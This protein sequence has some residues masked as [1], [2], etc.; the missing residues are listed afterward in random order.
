MNNK[1]GNSPDSTNFIL[2]QRHGLEYLTA[3]KILAGSRANLFKMDHQRPLA[4]LLGHSLELTF[5]GLLSIATMSAGEPIPFTHDLDKLAS[6]SNIQSTLALTND[7]LSALVV[8]N[9][10]FA[11]PYIARYPKL[12]LQL[13]P[14]PEAFSI[15]LNL[16][17]R[18]SKVLD[19]LAHQQNL[20]D[21]IVRKRLGAD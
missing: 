19:S 1:N 4:T 3:A 2:L 16:A 17:E 11:Y 6:D 9:G 13:F 5:K 14:N 12:G 15:L 18:L 20:D 21:P 8:L 7:D 10:V